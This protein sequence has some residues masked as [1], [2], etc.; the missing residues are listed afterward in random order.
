MAMKPENML[1]F[2]RA[3]RAACAPP[4]VKIASIDIGEL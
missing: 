2:Y 4:M 3:F 1:S